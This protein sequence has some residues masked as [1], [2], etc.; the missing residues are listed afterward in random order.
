MD[1]CVAEVYAWAKRQGADFGELLRAIKSDSSIIQA[2]LNDWIK[3]ADLRDEL[4]KGGG[5]TSLMDAVQVIMTRR[6]GA[7]NLSADYDFKQVKK[8]KL[9]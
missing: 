6:L 2:D 4:R 9:I 7:R 1:C 5:K 3:A 8:A